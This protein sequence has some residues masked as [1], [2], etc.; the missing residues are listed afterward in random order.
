MA[1]LKIILRRVRT[2][3]WTAMSILVILAAVL[4][5]VGQLLMPYSDHY[6]HRLEAWLSEEFGRPVVLESFE[7][8]WSVFGPRLTL[9]GMSLLPKEG[10]D[11]GELG[12]I[13]IK[14]AALEIKP[15]NLLI[16]GRPL[17]NFLVIGADLQLL[18][19]ADGRLELSGFG[20]TGRGKGES[21]SGLKELAKVGEVFLQDSSLEYLD[22]KFDIQ[23]KFSSINGRLHMDG[24]E[25]SAEIQASLYDAR[26]EL[27]Y[28][29][30]EATVL[31]VL[32]EDQKMAQTSWQA[33]A[34]ELML[35]ALQGKLP[36]NPVPAFDR[37]VQCRIVG[38]L[39][40]E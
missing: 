7:G 29:E 18:H 19:K 22:E 26:S 40:R 9:R 17:Y 13:A 2:L 23:F 39:V 21:S 14:S 15:L 33:S 32:D 38:G 34:R 10:D 1:S 36:A 5:G 12:V 35:A 16:P 37:L 28:G 3:I 11:P 6:Q 20:V 30:V 27:V 25:F 24:D 8:E 31:F 4:V